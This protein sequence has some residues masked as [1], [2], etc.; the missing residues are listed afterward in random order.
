[1]LRAVASSS[2]CSRRQLVNVA[3]ATSSYPSASSSSLQCL[4]TST[5]SLQSPHIST[6]HRPVSV[7]C[8]HTSYTC[9]SDPVTNTTQDSSRQ[10]DASPPPAYS[11]KAKSKAI[12]AAGSSR[13]ASQSS[14]A[15]A[16]VSD[17]S[18]PTPPAKES[19][20]QPQSPSPPSTASSPSP[21]PSQPPP[22][23]SSAQDPKSTSI[24]AKIKGLYHQ[25]KFLFRFYLNGVKQ[26]WVDRK[27]V[28]EI[29]ASVKS[30]GR[31]LE[32][33]EK[34]LIRVHS[35]DLKKLPLFLAILLILEEILP[36]VVIY[37]PSLLPS[38]CILPTQLLK[39]RQTEE[40]KR[41]AAI[42]RLRN[43]KEVQDLM[44]TAGWSVKAVGDKKDTVA[45]MEAMFNA[46]KGADVGDKFK[47]LSK[48][49]L[50][51][52]SKVFSLGTTL[53]PTSILRSN[54]E[55]H[56]SFLGKDDTSLRGLPTSTNYSQ[57]PESN[58]LL[59]EVSTQRGLR[60][61]EVESLEMFEN[62]RDWL[63]ITSK[64]SSSS[65]HQVLFLPLLLYP[66]PLFT[67][68][69]NKLK[70]LEENEATKGI[71][72][73]SKEVAQEVIKAEEEKALQDERVQAE[74]KQHS[75]KK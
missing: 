3:N 10:R 42:E 38:T 29:K 53:R 7:R 63:R 45:N 6:L 68:S 13:K 23:P 44:S 8:L 22:P 56:L 43:S 74:Q 37:A 9:S 40:I 21:T 51:D 50:I 62:L 46:G 41:S 1:M 66:A 57:L 72:E 25:V 34:R 70:I 18:R 49:T 54:L 28:Q 17:S 73:R 36:L 2:R 26:I 19:H 4:A 12:S 5:P 24:S 59:A 52:F 47:A 67:P 33:S 75:D 15:A 60:C 30:T 11:S 55:S 14:P 65:A 58:P 35:D 71:L 16:P 64:Q 69:L 20:L 31:Q 61:C 39:I 27:R 48:E 32:W